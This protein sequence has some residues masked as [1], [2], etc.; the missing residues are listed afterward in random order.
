MLRAQRRA[1]TRCLFEPAI[2][3]MTHISH[4]AVICSISVMKSIIAYHQVA[5]LAIQYL[6]SVGISPLANKLIKCVAEPIR[7]RY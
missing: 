3:V 5:M 6:L 2:K 1:I 4:E 7:S